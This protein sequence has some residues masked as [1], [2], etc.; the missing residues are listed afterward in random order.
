MRKF[1]PNQPATIVWPFFAQV[2]VTP[3][4][5]TLWS[6]GSTSSLPRGSIVSRQKFP[7]PVPGTPVR[8][9]RRM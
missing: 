6:S 2:R 3:P 4:S 8:P 1:E 7:A 5:V 9:W